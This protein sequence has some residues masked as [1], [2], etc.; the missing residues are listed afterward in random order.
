L[1]SYEL[2]SAIRHCVSV[3][4]NDLKDKTAIYLSRF[5][6]VTF[7][8]VEEMEEFVKNNAGR[9]SFGEGFVVRGNKTT[10]YA[11]NGNGEVKELGFKFDDGEM[12]EGDIDSNKS[13]YVFTFK[14]DG[15]D[16][17]SAQWDG[18]YPKFVRDKIDL[19]NKRG[20]FDEDDI[21]HL[22][23]EQYLLYKM[24]EGRSDLVYGLIKTICNACSYQN[25]NDYTTSIDGIID[26]WNNDSARA[27]FGNL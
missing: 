13:T 21:D 5:A 27:A 12:S 26:E 16:M 2:T 8:T 10:D 24:V 14:V 25:A 9:F 3:I 4:D 11:Y 23:S 22:S 18:Y 15:K 19:S 1:G 20:R 6:P 7:N 17:C